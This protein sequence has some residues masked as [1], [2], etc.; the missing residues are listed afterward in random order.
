MDNEMTTRKATEIATDAPMDF[1]GDKTGFEGVD[2]DCIQ[3]P[4]LKIAQASSDETKKM[5]AAYIP[6]LEPGMFFCPS[7]KTI[8]GSDINVVIAHFDRM[9]VVYEGTGK[10]SKYQGSITS[11]E[12]DRD[13]APTAVREKSYTLLNG[14]RYVDTRSFLVI[15]YDRPYDGAMMF[16]L[17]STGITPSKKL[18]TQA[19]NV[20]AM[21][22]GEPVTAPM[23]SSVWN[24]KTEYFSDPKGDYFQLAGINR[25]GWVNAKLAPKVKQLFED[26]QGIRVAPAGEGE[27]HVTV[28][29]PAN[30]ARQAAGGENEIF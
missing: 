3:T 30:M 17:S 28:A 8:Y 14:L 11:M 25:M 27:A 20:K 5:N 10:E 9:Y 16:S 12:Y 6:G 24:L 29:E 1:F 23:W 26:M 7:T 21:K 2:R 22:N 18:I 15:P 4:F 13:I 19:M